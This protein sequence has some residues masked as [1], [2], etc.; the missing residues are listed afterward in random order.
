M[1][2]ETVTREYTYIKNGKTIVV[3]RKYAVK[4][5]RVIKNSE[6][7]NYFKDNVDELTSRK[8]KLKD[9]VEEY[10]N[11]HSAHV[12]Y[13]KFYQKYKDVFGFRKNHKDK[14]SDSDTTTSSDS[15]PDNNNKPDPII[16][17]EPDTTNYDDQKD[18][19]I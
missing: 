2:A 11:S 7:D 8:K 18:T 9:I 17:T 14:S 3:K 10:N 12:S 4:G 5:D 16:N 15:E 1:E 19:I 6:L 13:S